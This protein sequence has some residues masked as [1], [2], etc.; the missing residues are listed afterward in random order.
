MPKKYWLLPLAVSLFILRVLS[1][2]LGSLLLLN[3]TS[4]RETMTEQFLAK[5]AKRLASAHFV[6]AEEKLL[7]LV[8]AHH[9]KGKVVSR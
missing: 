8:Q 7:F 5:N 2:R 6:P 1:Q 3:R 9:V 4:T